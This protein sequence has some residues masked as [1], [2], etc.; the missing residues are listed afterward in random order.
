[1]TPREHVYR[2]NIVLHTFEGGGGWGVQKSL[3][4]TD[5][6]IQMFTTT[7]TQDAFGF[8]KKKYMDIGYATSHRL[9]WSF[10]WPTG[11][12][13]SLFPPPMTIDLFPNSR[14]LQQSRNCSKEAPC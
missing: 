7:F 8:V 10:C 4:R 5:P 9:D 6:E 13:G 3:S 12:R 1:M 11:E 2:Q 14:Y